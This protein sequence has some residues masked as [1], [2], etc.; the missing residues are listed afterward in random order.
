MPDRF[1]Y[2]DSLDH[3][4]IFFHSLRQH[5]YPLPIALNSVP[6]ELIPAR[7]TDSLIITDTWPAHADPLILFTLA[8]ISLV[9]IAAYF[10]FTAPSVDRALFLMFTL[11]MTF[12]MACMAYRIRTAFNRFSFS[13]ADRSCTL[14][15]RRILTSQRHISADHVRVIVRPCAIKLNRPLFASFSGHIVFVASGRSVVVCAVTES[16]FAAAHYADALHAS[17]G[18]EVL[19]ENVLVEGHGVKKPGVKR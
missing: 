15:R 2:S 4:D 12:L 8:P 17:T 3:H 13:F 10:M 19:H 14:T 9:C 16:P 18:I 1:K 5:R 7:S 11:L 6:F